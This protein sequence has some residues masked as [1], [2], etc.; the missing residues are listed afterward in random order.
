M[1]TYNL[2][3][4]ASL[5]ILEMHHPP[6]FLEF[7][8]ASPQVLRWLLSNKREELDER[9]QAQLDQLFAISEEVQSV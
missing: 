2:G 3:D 7:K 1:F 5:Q 4:G 6:E 9:E 8:A